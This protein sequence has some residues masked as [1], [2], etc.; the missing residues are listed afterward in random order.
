MGNK[1]NNN[2]KVSKEEE[3]REEVK[4]SKSQITGEDRNKIRN[5]AILVIILI[6]ASYILPDIIKDFLR[7]ETDKIFKVIR[8]SVMIQIAI[9]SIAIKK[10]LDMYESLTSIVT[11]FINNKFR[12]KFQP[13]EK[14]KF[15]RNILLLLYLIAI[16]ILALPIVDQLITP[17]QGT[18]NQGLV[19]LFTLLKLGI[20]A[21]GLYIL[22]EIWPIIEAVVSRKGKNEQEQKGGE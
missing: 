2:K 5:G 19:K 8:I 4:E 1:E 20:V 7:E 21:Y 6:V 13:D 22:Y 15:T 14:K 12:D 11:V 16:S 9:L 10:L 3:T 17:N 18:P